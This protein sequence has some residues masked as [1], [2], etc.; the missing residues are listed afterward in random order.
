MSVSSVGGGSA[1]NNGGPEKNSNDQP[2]KVEGANYAEKIRSKLG[3]LIGIEGGVGLAVVACSSRVLANQAP[4]DLRGPIKGFSYLAGVAALVVTAMWAF[5]QNNGSEGKSGIGGEDLDKAISE[6]K[7]QISELDSLVKKGGNIVELNKK[8]KALDEKAQSL[9]AECNR[10]NRNEECLDKQVELLKTELKKL[11]EPQ[12]AGRLPAWLQKEVKR[13][14]S[15][16]EK[17]IKDQNS[18]NNVSSSNSRVKG[19]FRKYRTY[20]NRGF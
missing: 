11:S 6:L 1:A 9:G 17:L 18:G 10:S 3:K 5:G 14:N 2:G 20:K 19:H 8:I 4:M 12:Q 15:A 13:I 7:K 16:L